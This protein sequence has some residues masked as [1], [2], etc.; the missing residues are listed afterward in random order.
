MTHPSKKVQAQLKA[1]QEYVNSA[2]S[3]SDSLNNKNLLRFYVP[4]GFTPVDPKDFNY[5]NQVEQLDKIQAALKGRSTSLW[6][7][8]NDHTTADKYHSDAPELKQSDSGENTNEQAP[9]VE[10]TL[11]DTQ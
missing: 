3:L 8:N 6:S 11:E 5:K 4:T 1:A 9:T 2:L 10:S 7:K